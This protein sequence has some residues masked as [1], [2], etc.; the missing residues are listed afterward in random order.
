MKKCLLSAISVL[1]AVFVFA[2]EEPTAEWANKRISVD[3]NANDWD[4]PIKSYDSDTKLYFEIKNDNKNL[5][6]CFQSKDQMNQVKMIRAGMKI[7][8]TSKINGKHKANIEF[9]LPIKKDSIRNSTADEMSGD[10][11]STHEKM[12]TTFLAGDSIM[13]VKGFTRKDGM[14]SSHDTSDI[15]AAIN[16]DKD[17]ILTYEIAIPL[18]ELFGD[19]YQEKNIS[20][21]ISLDVIINALKKTGR[22]GG[23]NG[24]SGRGGGMGGGG[25]GRGMGMGRALMGM[26]GQRM[27]NGQFQSARSSM[28][29]KNELKTKFTLATK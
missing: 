17:N 1:I 11:A 15:H 20:K 21:N 5:Y 19:N 29:E 4:L 12:H 13:E 18:K 28:N 24:Y 2:Q 7:I 3:G 22:Q 6:L 8:L 10:P 9:P 23:G 16:W 26:G 27:G 25:F 14:I